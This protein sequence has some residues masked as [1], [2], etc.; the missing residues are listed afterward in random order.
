LGYTLQLDDRI[1]TRTVTSYRPAACMAVGAH[2]W[3]ARTV[4]AAGNRSSWTTPWT[5]AV[6]RC[7]F[8]IP[9]WQKH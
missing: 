2:T 9:V 7:E 5:F 8:Y 3:R 4:D 1:L 6:D